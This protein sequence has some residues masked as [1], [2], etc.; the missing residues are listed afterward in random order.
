M[1]SNVK[2]HLKIANRCS[3]NPYRWTYNITLL[4]IYF[5]LWTRNMNRCIYLVC[6]QQRDIWYLKIR[7][8][9]HSSTCKYQCRAFTFYAYNLDGNKHWIQRRKSYISFQNY[10]VQQKRA[11]RSQL[12]WRI[13]CDRIDT[14]INNR[15]RSILAEER[16]Y[17]LNIIRIVCTQVLLSFSV[18]FQ[19]Y[20]V[21]GKVDL[22]VDVKIVISNSGDRYLSQNK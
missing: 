15:S 5:L 16:W 12:I 10:T 20:E 6:V 19:M 17:V 22:K 11:S 13:K 2:P 8:K 1:L 7:S 18:S 3:Y 14:K 9:I 4:L 21:C